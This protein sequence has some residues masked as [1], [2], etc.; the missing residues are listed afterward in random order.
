ML[1][2]GGWGGMVVVEQVM[3]RRHVAMDGSDNQAR[4]SLAAGPSA[5]YLMT[6]YC[7]LSTTTSINFPKPYVS[8]ST[9]IF[10]VE[11]LSTRSSTRHTVQAYHNL[12]QVVLIHYDPESPLQPIDRLTARTCYS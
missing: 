12:I 5:E 3:G 10:E 9:S 11:H 7:L 2:I 6:S 4:L 8:Q 1:V